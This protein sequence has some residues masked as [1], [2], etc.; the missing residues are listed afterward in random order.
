MQPFSFV[1]R[2]RERSLP[3]LGLRRRRLPLLLYIPRQCLTLYFVA[4]KRGRRG[5]EMGRE[6][7]GKMGRYGRDNVPV[8][9][10]PKK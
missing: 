2:V 7:E 1:V 6:D 8:A 5:R 4:N 10:E 3:P 9:G